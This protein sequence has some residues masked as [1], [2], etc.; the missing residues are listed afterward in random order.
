MIIII[1]L[2]FCLAILFCIGMIFYT[3]AFVLMRRD[4]TYKPITKFAGNV[5]YDYTFCKR[6]E[7]IFTEKCQQFLHR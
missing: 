2:F 5:Y 6:N 1:V 7:S 3:V 4:L